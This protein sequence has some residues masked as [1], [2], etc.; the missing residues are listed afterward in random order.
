MAIE[1][2]LDFTQ[3]YSITASL[4]HAIPPAKVGITSPGVLDDNVAGSIP[5]HSVRVAI[6][7]FGSLFGQRPIALHHAT[8]GDAQFALAITRYHTAAV[9]NYP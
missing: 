7:G 5:R 4:D 1:S 2:R 8:A 6:E 9:V 3:F